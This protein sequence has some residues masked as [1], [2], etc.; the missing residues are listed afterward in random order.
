M[1]E[2][3]LYL[4]A[5]VL[6]IVSGVSGLATVLAFGL[7]VVNITDTD[8]NYWMWMTLFALWL[9]IAAPICWLSSKGVV[10]LWKRIG[11]NAV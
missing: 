10:K 3:S 1:S 8:P 9:L 6:M 5:F 11:H 2:L 7:I 4:L